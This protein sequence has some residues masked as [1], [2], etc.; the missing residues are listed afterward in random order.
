MSSS[1]AP[2]ASPVSAWNCTRKRLR[3]WYLPLSSSRVPGTYLRCS[4]GWLKNVAS[5]EPVASATTAVTSGFIPRLRTGRLVIERTST[6]TVATSSI[7]SSPIVR[8]LW[9]SRGRWLEQV[10]DRLQPE[11]LGRGGG[12]GRASPRAAWRSRDGRG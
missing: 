6:I 12:L 2:T 7:A 3:A 10:A 9:R 1:A 8:A 5:I 4:H 11:P